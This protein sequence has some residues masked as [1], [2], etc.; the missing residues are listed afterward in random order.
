MDSITRIASVITGWQRANQKKTYVITTS[1]MKD[2]LEKALFLELIKANQKSGDILYATDSLFVNTLEELAISELQAVSPVTKAPVLT[3]SLRAQVVEQVLSQI[4]KLE[5]F[6]KI[7]NQQKSGFNLELAKLFERFERG[8][9]DYE[10][11]KELTPENEGLK[12]KFADIAKI[13]Q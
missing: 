6:N 13:Y 5:V 4:D 7:K 12:K 9:W 3:M 2:D 10:T 1:A 8:G 11:F